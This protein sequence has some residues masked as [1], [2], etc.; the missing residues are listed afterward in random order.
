MTVYGMRKRLNGHCERKVCPSCKLYGKVCRCGK[1]TSFL[2]KTPDDK[3]EMSDE[4]IED[5][6]KIVFGKSTITSDEERSITTLIAGKKLVEAVEKDSLQSLM[7]ALE[8]AKQLQ[9]D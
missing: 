2:S 3:F 5:A 6:Y 1:G 9:E 8:Y 4:E 7:E